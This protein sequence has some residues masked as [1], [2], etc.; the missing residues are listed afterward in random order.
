L[1]SVWL[2]FT[3]CLAAIAVSGTQLSRWG[4]VL[5]EKTGLGRSWMGLAVVAAI[6][7]LPEL[8]SGL[9]AV[10]WVKVPD[11]AVGNLLGACVLN[12]LLLA[13]SDLIYPPAPLLTAAARGHLI[14]AGFALILLAV[15]G[16]ALTL[17]AAAGTFRLGHVGAST[18]LLLACYLL[19]MQ[20]TF[21]FHRRERR[22]YLSKEEEAQLYPHVSL[23]TALANFCLHALVVVVMATWLPRVATGLAQALEWHLSAVGT[24]FVALVTTAPE[25]VVTVGA[26]RLGAVDL[27]VGDLLGSIIINCAFVAIVDLFYLEGPILAGVAPVHGGTA[28]LALLMTGIAVAEMTY[29]PQH[30]TMRVLSLGAFVLVFLYGVHLYVQIM[31]AAG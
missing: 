27:A 7:S 6:T 3:L 22:E 11:V 20:A 12:L 28:L 29:R 17:P 10:T 26:L 23:N 9:S 16:L 13:L 14:A 18:P 8:V 4:D 2:Q 1:G 31:A 30:K 24:I 19:A 21:R 15:I 5:A 25:L